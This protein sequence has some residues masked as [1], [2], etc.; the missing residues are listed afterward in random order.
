MSV[1]VISRK[2]DQLPNNCLKLFILVFGLR[3][4]FV[5]NALLVGVDSFPQ[6]K[7][8]RRVM[9]SLDGCFL[10]LSLQVLVGFS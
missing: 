8:L 7:V 4:E 6:L 10:Q 5:H 1:S 3:L 9:V 2:I